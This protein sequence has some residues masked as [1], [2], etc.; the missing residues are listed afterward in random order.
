MHILLT[1]GTGFIGTALVDALHRAG[2]HT[3]ILT[4]RKCPSDEVNQYVSDLDSLSSDTPIDAVINLAGASLADK[5]WSKRYKQEVLA[6]RFNTTEQLVDLMARLHRKPDVMLSASAVGYYGH[7][8]GASF[9]ESDESGS[10]FSAELCSRW[11]SI[12]LRAESLGVRVCLLRLGVVLSGDGGAFTQMALPFRLGIANWMGHGQQWLS[13]VHRDDVVAAV[14]FL[15]THER[16]HGPFNLTAPEAV[17]SRGFCHAMKQQRRSMVTLPIPATV[18]RLVVGEMAEELLLNGQRVQP[19]A[20]Q[21]A[22]FQFRY[23]TLEAGL[24]EILS[25]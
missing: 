20:L 21:A 3:T 5:R 18:M 14:Q 16:L 9:V 11:E 1:G 12:A 23:P 8:L 25:S 7:S 6:S 10:G 15:L 19:A 22:G 17:T 2:H 13:W 4:R 24:A